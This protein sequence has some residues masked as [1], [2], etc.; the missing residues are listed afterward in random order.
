MAC[1][2]QQ[3]KYGHETCYSNTN[4]SVTE[5]DSTCFCLNPSPSFLYSFFSPKSCVHNAY[6]LE[7]CLVLLN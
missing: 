1:H 4:T 7:V 2:I 3:K 6:Y 5:P